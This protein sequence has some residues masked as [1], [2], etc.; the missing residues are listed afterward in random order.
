MLINVSPLTTPTDGFRIAV[1]SS[2]IKLV[3]AINQ[4]REGFERKAVEFQDIL[5]MGRTQLQDAV[6]MT[7]GQ[8][9]RFQH[10]AERRSEKY[11]N[12][13]LKLLLE[14]NLGATAIGTGLNTPKSTLRW[15]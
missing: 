13:P 3:D 1:Y 8:D 11:P 14:V 12:V 2:L 4:L 6:P 10:P 15:Q 7:L 5:K 9:S